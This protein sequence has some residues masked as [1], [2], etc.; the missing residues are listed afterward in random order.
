MVVLNKTPFNLN[1]RQ[2]EWVNETINNMTLE[3]KI[4]QLF[5]LL[6]PN[7]GIDEEK[8]SEQLNK[9]HQGGLRWQGGNKEEVYKQN[10]TFQKHS[11]IP[12]LI[13]GNCDDGGVGCLPTEGTFVATAAQAAAN[14][15]NETAYHMGLVSGREATSIGCNWLFNPVVDIYMNWRNTIVNTRCFG[16]NAETVIKNAKAYIKGVKDANPNMACCAKHFPGD[17][18]EELDQH[19]VLGVN[20]LD[21][22]QWEESFGKAYQSM[23]DDGIESI[24]VGHIAFPEMSKKLRPDIKDSE[25]MPATL[26]PELLQGLLRDKMNFNGLI[27]TDATHMIGFSAAKSREEALPLAIA[28]GC[29]MILF[30]N[31]IEEDIE[32]IKNG[33]QEGIISHD[34]LEDA[35][36]RIIGLKAK[37]NLMD[38]SV[39]F[40]SPDL[41]DRWVSCRE[42][43]NFRRLAADKCTT[44]V[45][46]TAKFIPINPKDKKNIYLVYVQSTPNS[47]AYEGD[48][49]KDVVEE[50]LESQGFLVHK[51]PNFYDLEVENG[52]SPKNMGIMMDS[53]STRK[54]FKELYDLALIVINVKGYA[55]E[56]NVR[57]RWSCHHSVEIPWY[58]S[59]IPTIGIS[60]NYTNHLIDIPQ[61]RTFINAYGSN[62]ENIRAAIEKMCGLSD[63]NGIAS[64]T[65][66]C[67]RWETRL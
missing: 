51:A 11:Q 30:A 20:D 16:D 42:H 21:V 67:D 41:K 64:E 49:V 44:L 47:K 55:Q 19:L 56:N 26:A 28:S 15:S 29:D 58:V 5:V 7:Q 66:F 37:L 2:I 6:K 59:E 45:K 1:E 61:V 3:E 35:V 53:R 17:G 24:M 40:P 38:K 22:D 34:R 57:L 32:F 50:E 4:G 39:V 18:V 12:L 23:I 14:E 46:D 60:L 27:I 13:A 33:I 43:E 9:Y 48:P 63:F 52:P 65:V 8:I 54:E 36:I 31:D 25:I 10:M 62:R